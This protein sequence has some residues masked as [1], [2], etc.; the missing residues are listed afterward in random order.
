MLERKA[1]TGCRDALNVYQKGKCFYCF[2]DISV[3][4]ASDDLADVDHFF[5]HTLKPHSVDDV[6]DGVWNLVLA[7]QTCNRGAKGKFAQ[8]PELTFLE[9]LHRRN[10]FLI[11]SNHPLRETL[12]QQ[13]GV[14]ELARRQFLQTMYHRSKELLVRNWKPEYEHEPA[15]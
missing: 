13:T 3:E 7:C 10:S 11:D 8:L 12:I 9:R 1:I 5:P 6:I 4:S 15:F 2:G 14:N